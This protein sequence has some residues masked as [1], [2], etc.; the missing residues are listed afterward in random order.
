M[1]KLFVV[2]V[3]ILIPL[4]A[5]AETPLWQDV[6]PASIAIAGK[7]PARPNSYRTV[8][9]NTQALGSLLAQAPLEFTSAA[10]Q[11]IVILE[12]P[13]PD[14]RLARFRIEE[15]PVLA[16]HVAA[17]LPGVKTFSG[18]GI[19]EPAATAR[20]DWIPSKGFHGYILAQAGT[21]Y[22]DP[23]QE[24]D[25]EHYLVYCKHQY[26]GGTK[27]SS[28]HCDSDSSPS[29]IRAPYKSSRPIADFANGADLRT[30]RIAIAGTGEYTA[31]QGGQA[32]AL[33]AVTTAVNRLTGIYRREAAISFTLVSGTNIL[34]PDAATDPYTNAGDGG[35]LT[36]NQTQLDMIIGAANYDIGHLFVTS[37]GGIATTPCVCTG[38][39][40]EG[41]SGLA[42]PAGDP[43]VVD[44]VAHEIGHQFSGEHSYNNSGDG[45]CTT[46]SAN[47]AFEPASGATLMS[48]VGQCSPRDLAG[49]SLDLFT[50]Q[51]L[52]QV[53]NSRNDAG[54]G[55]SCGTLTTPG[56]TP[57]VL[58][59]LANFTIPR[60]RRFR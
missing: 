30:Y 4:G 13:M 23:Y 29:L 28:F 39:K 32:S 40:A 2:L 59:A 16:P 43:F 18:Q 24:N 17:E 52:T 46:R 33:A 8:R 48:Y 42:M 31:S 14:G 55:G 11:K 38:Q 1:P 6:N 58:G 10:R 41:L 7:R 9:L 3:L 51:S 50:V 47:N 54:G 12:V 5:F 27:R 37:D 49:N 34:F 20:F 19:D 26:G 21:V 57:P 25:R 36:V 22:I 15:S 53:I 35:Q 60:I 56:N 45:V 44:F